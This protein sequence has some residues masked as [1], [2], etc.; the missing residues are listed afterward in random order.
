M[1]NVDSAPA[2]IPP[3]TAWKLLKAH[4]KRGVLA[5]GVYLL[6]VT[7]MGVTYAAHVSPI[8]LE[9]EPVKTAF[10]LFVAAVFISVPQVVVG[11]LAVAR[12]WEPSQPGW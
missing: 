4:A 8:E 9:R 3:L 2:S 5:L 1:A 11:A 6:V 10:N 12:L 7:I